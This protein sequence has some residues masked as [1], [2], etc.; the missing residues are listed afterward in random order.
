MRRSLILT[1]G[2]TVAVVLLALLIPI[3]VLLRSYALEDR[4]SRAALEV[5]ATESV[6]SGQ[7]SDLGAVAHYLDRIN[8]ADEGII[9]TV[10]YPP[11]TEHPE[12]LIVGPDDAREDE[13]IRE[14]RRT[15]QA[16]IDDVEGGAEFLVPVSLG[17]VN[18]RPEDT[19]VVRVQVYEESF[20]SPV[21][22]AWLVL[23]LLG[24]VV[25]GAALVLADRLGRSFVQPIRSLAQRAQQL[26]THGHAE[27]ITV[28]G[29]AEVAELGAALNR[30]VV[31]IEALLVREREGVADLSHRLRTPI[32]ALRL[33]IDSL[34]DPTERARLSADA[35]RLQAMVDD[36]VREARRGQREGLIATADAGAVVR[37][38]CAFWQPLAEDQRRPFTVTAP[39]T[40]VLVAVSVEDVAALLDVLLDN[41]FS[42][43]PEGAGIVVSLSAREGGGAIVEVGDDGPGFP[44]GVDVSARGASGAGSTGL[45]LSIAARTAAV[46]GGSV[47]IG[48]SASGGACVRVEL[49][50]PQ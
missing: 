17:G 35:D 44:D 34:T 5:Q 12:G 42:H 15:G 14:A 11:S 3:A 2:A 46:A 31:R 8:S 29:P 6:V 23:G 7:A 20:P 16:R 24:L 37:E 9:T 26:G 18:A 50:P 25:F 22:R 43:T 36:V 30:L 40:P 28:E 33:G 48:S 47:G 39:E 10:Y 38:R 4:L 45:G 32:T 1:V 41:V 49:G 19:P 21:H 27:P 13:R